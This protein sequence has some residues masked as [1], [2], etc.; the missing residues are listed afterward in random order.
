MTDETASA[1]AEM[2]NDAFERAYQRS[3]TSGGVLRRTATFLVDHAQCSPGAFFEDFELTIGS[4]TSAL[5]YQATKA[6][7]A[8]QNSLP[9]HMARLSV[10]AFNGVK[11]EPASAKGEWL[12]EAL[13]QAGR[14]IVV[15][16]FGQTCVPADGAVGKAIR[17]LRLG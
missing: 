1:P 9:F 7:Q 6:S 2:K 4:L 12:W 16:V 15:S 13:G 10:I 14:M 17:S 11:V 3:T 8:D 5:E